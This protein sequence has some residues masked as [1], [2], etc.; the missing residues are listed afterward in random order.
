MAEG[1]ILVEEQHPIPQQIS[2]F[3][4]RLVGDMTLKQFVQLAG[5]AIVALLFYAS[6]LPPIVKWP[7]IFFSFGAGAALAFLPLEDRPLGK[8][9]VSFFK[10]IYSPTV[11]KWQKAAVE[12]NYFA[13]ET[14]L[15]PSGAPSATVVNALSITKPVQKPEEEKLEEKE[16]TFLKN[17]TTMSQSPTTTVIAGV[18]PITM[19]SAPPNEKV[20]PYVVVP[21]TQTTPL[22]KDEK[23][24]GFELPSKDTPGQFSTSTVSPFYGKAAQITKRQ[25][26]FSEEAAP[27][28][29]PTTLNTVVGQV[30]DKEGKI[31][32]GAILEIKD[33]QGRPVRAL[34]TNKL[35]HFM[36]VTPLV[37]GRYEMLIEKEGFEFE[38]ITFEAK[39]EIISPISIKS[40]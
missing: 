38:P 34:K 23:Q 31:I 3:Q 16:Q 37:S 17:L 19:P 13:S 28:T 15:A 32:E 33:V 27:P 36:I 29:P 6:G 7:L 9:V 30:M 35:G 8:W 5:G 11:F 26:S 18:S 21:T 22:A 4:F 2:A 10:S 40:K 25:A 12:P 1:H 39:G 14:Q 20:K 24:R